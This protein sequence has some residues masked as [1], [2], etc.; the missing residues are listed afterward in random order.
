MRRNIDEN[1]WISF[2]DMMTGL[3]VIFMFIAIAYIIE[4]KNKQN[5]VENIAEGYKQSKRLMHKDLDSLISNNFKNS[6]VELSEDL[7]VKFGNP[8]VLF[9]I[10]QSDL[11]PTFQ[12]TLDKFL[13]QYLT[14]IAQE[15]YINNISEIRIEGHTDTIP[16][17]SASNA[18]ENYLMCI[19][20]SQQ[21]AKQVLA[22]VRN[23]K[24]Y[25]SLSLENRKRLDFLLTCNGM[26]Y[27]R[28]L[29]N[30]KSLTYLSGKPVNNDNSRRVEFRIITTS[31]KVVESILNK[32]EK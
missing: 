22:Y 26:A 23:S 10:G 11:T 13:P 7:S 30:N 3:M 4:V 19:E 20:L 8:D 18:E 14:L 24:S 16:F 5:A 32:I 15:K 27:G 2:S 17:K 29:D 28:A 25:Q 6:D 31:E 12:Q 9:A 21:R 1:Y